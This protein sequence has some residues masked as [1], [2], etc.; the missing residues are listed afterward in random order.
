MLWLC[1]IAPP[2]CFTAA[3][4]FDSDPLQY[5][6]VIGGLTPIGIACSV[7]VFFAIC[8]PALLS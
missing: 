2:I 7:F 5:A 4:F 3:P 6:L 8:F 1:G